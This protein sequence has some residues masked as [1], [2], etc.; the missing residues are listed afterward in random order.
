M[1]R[2]TPFILKRHVVVGN[3]HH[4]LIAFFRATSM[5]VKFVAATAKREVSQ[6]PSRLRQEMKKAA[7]I[8]WRRGPRL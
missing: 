8:A 1:A 7:P 4:C 5:L 2:N 3:L 6:S